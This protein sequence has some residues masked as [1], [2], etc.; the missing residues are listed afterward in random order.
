MYDLGDP[1]GLKVTVTDPTGA[2]AD[3]TTVVC[4]ITAPD[5]TTT[6]PTVSHPSTGTY[7][8]TYTATQTGR[9]QV[10]WRATGTNASA[11]TDVFDVRAAGS[12]QLISLADAKAMLNITTTTND[13]ELRDYIAAT[14]DAV[15]AECGAMLPRTVTEYTQ[16]VGRTM[17]LSQ[18]PVVSITSMN[19]VLV[20]G[21]SFDPAG[22]YVDSATGIVLRKD[23]GIFPA[24]SYVVTY[25]AGR[26]NVVPAAV[27][28]AARII[29][30]WLWQ[31]QRGTGGRGD[32][33]A[34]TAAGFLI[35][36]QAA[37]LLK[38]YRRMGAIV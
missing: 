3:A 27:A 33:P 8:V 5:L 32:Q 25:V 14:T 34:P 23:R 12:V 30:K 36:N 26:G 29:L 28:M 17:A 38:P 13:E 15:E 31:T 6:T 1:V 7:T 37:E 18:T 35:P 16:P 21:Y 4:T 9:H 22:L 10:D 20:G 19:T 2:V 24:D 11:F